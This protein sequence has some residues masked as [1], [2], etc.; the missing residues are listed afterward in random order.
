MPTPP[1]SVKILSLEGRSH[2]TKKEL[3]ISRPAP[4]IR[5]TAQ[6]MVLVL[7]EFFLIVIFI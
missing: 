1:K 6:K 4:M 3:A 5:R 2:R 7:E